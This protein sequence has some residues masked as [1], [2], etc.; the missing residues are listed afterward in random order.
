MKIDENF[1]V[2][3]SGILKIVHK[4]RANGAVNKKRRIISVVKKKSIINK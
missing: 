1:F 3:I 4:S 2:R